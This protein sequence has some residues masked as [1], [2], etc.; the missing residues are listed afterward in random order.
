M[1]RGRMLRILDRA[2]ATE[3]SVGLMMSGS[4]AAAA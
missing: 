3:E 4:W 1:F 2:E